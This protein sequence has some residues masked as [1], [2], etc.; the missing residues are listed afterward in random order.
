MGLGPSKKASAQ[1]VDANAANV[2]ASRRGVYA[3]E[4]A[5]ARAANPNSPIHQ[6]TDEQIDEF[7]EAFAI[8]DED[9]GGSIDKSELG[10]VMKSLGQDPSDAELEHMIAMADADGSGDI[11]FYEFTTLIAHRMA[12]DGGFANQEHR[13][14]QAFSVFDQNGDGVIDASE[15]RRIMCNLGE[16]MSLADV[17]EVLSSFD[18]N[19]DG[20]ID[21]EEFAAAVVSQK[22]F[23]FDGYR[24]G[25]YRSPLKVPG[26]GPRSAV[27]QGRNFSPSPKKSPLMKK[28][29]TTSSS[30]TAG[31]AWCT[32]SSAAQIC[33]R[34]S[35]SS[36]AA[37][38]LAR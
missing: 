27:G 17:D 36:R 20:T 4:A 29:T 8:F 21:M 28:P 6:L 19:G 15:M 11:D 31:G 23:G 5:R 35:H 16:T 9:G 34:A 14:Q 30:L 26:Y 3:E 10:S 2:R 24:E 18:G 33:R 7:K 13:M 32:T 22:P 12:Q 25:G 38:S 1:V 37:S